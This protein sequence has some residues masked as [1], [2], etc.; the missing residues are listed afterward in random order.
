[1]TNNNYVQ[2]CVYDIAW[3]YGIDRR[4]YPAPK[5]IRTV[6]EYLTPYRDEICGLCE[7]RE[8]E[9]LKLNPEDE[10]NPEKLPEYDSDKLEKDFSQMYDCNRCCIYDILGTYFSSRPGGCPPSSVNASDP[11]ISIWVYN[12]V[13][14]LKDRH[15]KKNVSRF[16]A[17]AVVSYIMASFFLIVPP[18]GFLSSAFYYT[19]MRISHSKPDSYE[20]IRQTYNLL[21]WK[22]P[23]FWVFVALSAWSGLMVPGVPSPYPYPYPPWHRRYRGYA[24][25]M[26]DWEHWWRRYWEHWRWIWRRWG[27]VIEKMGYEVEEILDLGDGVGSI[28]RA[29]RMLDVGHF[30]KDVVDEFVEILEIDPDTLEREL[31]KFFEQAI[32]DMPMSK[33]PFREAGQYG[34]FDVP[35]DSSQVKKLEKQEKRELNRWRNLFLRKFGS[36]FHLWINRIFNYPPHPHF[37]KRFRVGL[38]NPLDNLIT[39]VLH[40]EVGH[41]SDPYLGVRVYIESE[42]FADAYAF[43]EMLKP[44]SFSSD[45][46]I[47][48]HVL[49]GSTGWVKL[50]FM[51]ARDLLKRRLITDVLSPVG[52]SIFVK[53]MRS[54][55]ASPRKKVQRSSVLVV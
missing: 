37:V 29:E 19:L 36:R 5:N 6:H 34:I 8:A 47:F 17:R 12:N 43:G 53:D 11:L 30:V 15:T 23:P 27:R 7:C 39:A 41:A 49:I 40:H 20:W 28:S 14:F 46:A 3:E 10:F 21:N 48:M 52:R 9:P 54:R 42:A 24:G 4:R 51:S 38:P 22:R 26:Y 1:M 44:K 31:E 32:D 55:V 2:M 25:W 50:A 13:K 16:M 18:R 35:A 45:P 33:N